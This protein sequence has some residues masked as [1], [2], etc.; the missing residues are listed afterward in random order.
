MLDISPFKLKSEK[1]L[2][3]GNVVECCEEVIWIFTKGEVEHNYTKEQTDIAL[4]R[5][6]SVINAY[7]T[8]D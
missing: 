6:S 3:R 7:R 1:E 4:A 5:L 2:L 8:E